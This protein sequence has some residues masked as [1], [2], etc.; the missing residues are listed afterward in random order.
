MES[1]FSPVADLSDRLERLQVE[2]RH[3]V[4]AAVADESPIQLRRDGDA[5]DARRIGN[6]A[7][8]LARVEVDH[9]DVG[10]MGDV[11]TTRGAIDRQVVPSAFATDFDFAERVVTG[12]GRHRQCGRQQT[13]KK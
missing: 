2:D 9:R 3:V 7:D 11:E 4:R 12:G 13:E 5:V 6:V 8:D 1:G 10:R